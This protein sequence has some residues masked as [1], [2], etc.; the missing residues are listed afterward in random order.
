M[1]LPN[2]K[3]VVNGFGMTECIGITTTVDIAAAPTFRTIPSMPPYSTG[4]LYPNTSLKILDIETGK[5]LEPNKSGEITFKSPLLCAGYWKRPEETAKTFPNG[6]MRTGDMGYY[7]ENGF[8]FVSGRIK[9]NFKYYN[10]HVS[11]GISSNKCPF[12]LDSFE[13]R[14]HRKSWKKLFWIMKR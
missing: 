11:L 3:L 14:F 4:R 13:S 2:V 6:W 10:N 12:I 9:D 7:D 8:L 1:K 5:A